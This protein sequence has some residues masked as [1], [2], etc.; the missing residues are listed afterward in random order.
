MAKTEE[1]WNTTLDEAFQR[2]HQITQLNQSYEEKNGFKILKALTANVDQD[3]NKFRRQNY[4]VV[5]SSWFRGNQLEIG[6][7]LVATFVNGAPL[8]YI[9]EATFNTVLYISWELPLGSPLNNVIHCLLWS[10][11]YL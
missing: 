7:L 10:F 1:H 11:K 5:M 8:G 9:R 4:Q 2:P 6:M 3:M